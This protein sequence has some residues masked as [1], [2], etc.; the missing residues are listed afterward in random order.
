ML[1]FFL[2]LYPEETLY[3]C[4][5]RNHKIS[6]NIYI[7]DTINK[8]FGNNNNNQNAF[9]N[10]NISFLCK[11]LPKE[12]GYSIQ[13][14]LSNNSLYHFYKPFIYSEMN[15]QGLKSIIYKL[16]F[17][18][19]NFLWVNI[20][21]GQRSFKVCPICFQNDIKKYGEPY[22][23]RIHQV[24]GNFIC[25]IHN[26]DLVNIG[27]NMKDFINLDIK[28]VKFKKNNVFANDEYIR[29]T[30]N[31]K[32]LLIFKL[33]DDYNIL[34]I[35]EKYK[36][37]LK[38]KGYYSY[39]GTLYEK[40]LVNDFKLYYSKE[41]LNRLNSDID[42]D[43]NRNWIRIM[44]SNKK[45]TITNPIRHLLFMQFLFGGISEF[46]NYKYEELK[47]FGEP[48]WPCLNPCCPEYLKDVIETSVIV[49]NK[50]YRSRIT[51]IF[52]CPVCGM[53]YSR[54]GPDKS[55]KDRYNGH[56]L[57]YGYIWDKRFME[58]I[59]C[60][61]VSLR[62][63]ATIMNCDKGTVKR[64][65]IRLNVIDKFD[66]IDN[67]VKINKKKGID[68]NIIKEDEQKILNLKNSDSSLMRYEICKM[69]PSETDR[70]RKF[71]GEWFEKNMP[72]AISN[73]EKMKEYT[74]SYWK[75]KDKQISQEVLKAIGILLDRK[76]PIRITKTKIAKMINYY[77]INH[78]KYL[79]KMP[80]TQQILNKYCES[81][82]Q[83]N[84][85]KN[86]N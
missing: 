45:N 4:I 21:G 54:V 61:K 7:K 79:L 48:N 19:P 52:G 81:L 6:G 17:S 53:K 28:N 74:N 15:S 63:M 75:E 49:A 29:L 85:R 68:L 72:R 86:H 36:Q 56:I 62:Y 32:G 11:Q 59:K 1:N 25:E 82:G 13:F 47:P 33:L 66:C 76:P 37:M 3:S 38:Q 16:S 31:I 41:F 8:L 46:N 71:A 64:Q 60:N 40:K 70:V 35:I 23:H 27:H 50:Q 9:A 42:I 14:F 83:F 55:L 80:L 84:Y 18:N 24:P 57:E 22:L 77:G 2:K 43:A 58:N 69:L 73:N 34:Q 51:G 20:E 65:A 12:L 78:L 44:L 39:N 5:A 10:L 26:T 67:H 30:H